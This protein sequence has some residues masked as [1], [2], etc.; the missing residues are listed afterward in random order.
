MTIR[1]CL[2]TDE[3]LYTTSHNICHNKPILLLLFDR[4][5][6]SGDSDVT[7]EF[8]NSVVGDCGGY[9]GSGEYGVSCKS[10]NSGHI[11]NI[12]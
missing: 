12:I 6:E 10:R 4:S 7:G 5:G 9:G 3:L 2:V 11:A 8:G 1:H